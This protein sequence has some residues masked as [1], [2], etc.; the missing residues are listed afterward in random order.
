[1]TRTEILDL[2]TENAIKAGAEVVRGRNV[3]DLNRMAA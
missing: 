2:F 1:M 3:E